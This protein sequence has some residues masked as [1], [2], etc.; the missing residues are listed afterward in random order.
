ME[1]DIL[2]YIQEFIRNDILNP[3]MIFLTHSGDYGILCILAA[4]ILIFIPKTRRLGMITGISIA[5]EFLMNNIILK[6]LVARTRPYEVIEELEI[7]IGRQPDYSFPS[8][9]S[10]VSFAFAGA[11]LFALIFGIPGFTDNRKYKTVTILVL[12]Y[13]TIVAFSRVYV[14]VHYPT[15]VIVGALLGII[16]G[17]ASYFIVKKLYESRKTNKAESQH[18]SDLSS[19]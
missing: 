3:I 8:G 14:G 17:V 9:H 5:L 10:G 11:L 1:A 16:S 19:D 15:D 12:I 2:L 7:L 13:A 18:T 4:L 6:N